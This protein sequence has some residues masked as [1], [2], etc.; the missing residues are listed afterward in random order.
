M[1]YLKG[2]GNLALA[3]GCAFGLL[4]LQ[5]NQVI[6]AVWAVVI[7]WV[8]AVAIA[9]NGLLDLKTYFDNAHDPAHAIYISL[10]TILVAPVMGGTLGVVILAVIAGWLP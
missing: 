1:E 10:A 5:W 7:V 3:G 2:V 8:C 6:I 9:L 4:F